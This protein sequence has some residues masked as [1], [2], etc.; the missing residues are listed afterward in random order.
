MKSIL[1][2]LLFILFTSSSN[3]QDKKA[4]QQIA[5]CEQG[6]G[7]EIMEI[8]TTPEAIDKAL[9]K[10][11][12]WINA[13][14]SAT[15]VIENCTH[16]IEEKLSPVEIHQSFGG[17]GAPKKITDFDLAKY[18]E[19][20]RCCANTTKK[21]A[22]NGNGEGYSGTGYFFLNIQSDEAYMPNDAFKQMGWE[23]GEGGDFVIDQFIR[24]NVIE[25]YTIAEGKKYYSVVDMGSHLQQD[26]LNE[27]RFKTDFKK[28]GK[29]RKYDGNNDVEY[30][31][32]DDEGRTISVWL[33]PSRDVC[34]P[35]G[36]FDMVG[37]YNLGYFSVDGITYLITELSGPNFHLKVTGI[38]DGS[39]SFNPAGYK[40]Y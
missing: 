31:G 30:V 40:S 25:T 11:D 22:F 7:C 39:Y 14:D 28:T 2:F 20:K 21:I 37:F 36:K 5:I 1:F 34:L 18:L 27:D 26:K 33:T 24:N 6:K 23:H 35:K 13:A 9:S 38:S 12:F 10:P 15:L 32:K 8:K 3:A 19:Q 17:K 29:T 16:K 4:K